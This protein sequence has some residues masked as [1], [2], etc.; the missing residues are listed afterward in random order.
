MIEPL[1][2]ALSLN[3]DRLTLKVIM[4]RIFQRRAEQSRSWKYL[5]SRRAIRT[6]SASR[7]F[8]A[9]KMEQQRYLFSFVF[10]LLTTL[11]TS[12][13]T[14]VNA[15]NLIALVWDREL[16]RGQPDTTIRWTNSLAPELLSLSGLIFAIL[17]DFCLSLRL[18]EIALHRLRERLQD[19]DGNAAG[20][21]PPELVPYLMSAGF[22]EELSQEILRNREWTL[23]ASNVVSEL[24][25]LGV[26]DDLRTD[27]RWQ[28]LIR[29][30]EVVVVGPA[31]DSELTSQGLASHTDAFFIWIAGVR[32]DSLTG[33]FEKYGV[34][35][36]AL[37]IA[38]N[39]ANSRWI[40]NNRHL[41]KPGMA[42]WLL[43]K[44]QTT[45]PLPWNH[46]HLAV[47]TALP[48]LS[49]APNLVPIVVADA[50]LNRASSVFIYGTDF[51]IGTDSY[52]D[53]SR[54]HLPSGSDLGPAI[55]A[56]GSAGQPRDVLGN[57]ARH[58]PIENFTLMKALASDSSV[59][60]SSVFQSAIRLTSSQYASEL[61]RRFC[62]AG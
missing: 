30:R 19:Q 46:H 22:D 31:P 27:S 16:S 51:F 47:G 12:R 1:A 21:I 32:P 58:D 38:L 50:L 36:S 4:S 11:Y 9:L 53:E 29:G 52:R 42:D 6:L 13:W 17:G 56:S 37:G 28:D 3:R 54:Y 61:E 2:R 43:S 25:R 48:Y 34:L 41:L 39:G 55:D 10:I 44:A 20:V 15:R 18:K 59:D 23:S 26:S 40:M 60:G 45:E 33:G 14:F 49:G 7:F 5:F 8:G 62:N 24:V 35:P 57:I